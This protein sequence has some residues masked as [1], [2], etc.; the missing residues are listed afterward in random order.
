MIDHRGSRIFKEKE[1]T[2]ARNMRGNKERSREQEL[3][4]ENQKLRREISSLRKQLA[5]LDLDR[6]SYVKDIVDEHLAHEEQETSAVH[7]LKKLK[8]A[9]RCNKCKDGYLEIFTYN[10]INE[11]WYRRECNI[12]DNK[13]KAQKYDP[14]HVQ[15][16]MK[17]ELKKDK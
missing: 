15:G 14:D 17:Q 6:H 13:T 1:P 10:K 11:T 8:E 3:K 7:M 16:I 5:R 4:H 9:W 2:L 12:C